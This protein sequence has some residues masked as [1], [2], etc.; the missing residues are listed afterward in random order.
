[1]HYTE[2]TDQRAFNVKQNVRLDL[3][4]LHVIP[5]AGAGYERSR[6]PLNF[7]LDGRLE[8]T[9]THAG[10]GVEFK[11]GERTSFDLEGV[12]RRIS[13][14]DET[15]GGVDL[16]ERL[17]RETEEARLSFRYAL[18]PLTTFVA[19]T[20][21]QRDRFEFDPIRDSDSLRIV[22]GLEFE[23]FALISG[24]VMIGVQQFETRDDEVPDFT[25]LVAEVD[26]AYTVR[27]VV[28]FTVRSTRDVQYS[29]EPLEPFFVNSGVE[30]EVVR[31]IGLSWD[32]VARAGRTTLAYQA[33]ED[34]RLLGHAERTDLVT[35][36]GAG[37][38]R[39]LGEEIR[40]GIDII[41]TD[42]R[43]DRP[44]RGYSG[45]RTGGSLTYGF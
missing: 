43:S 17:N 34:G 38:G 42:R 45:W 24:S 11:P 6:R 15:F 23:P 9:R 18:T 32:V 2:A 40:V 29:I 33:T 39:H 4:L 20:G 12:K 14:G 26:V 27:D 8:E 28:R 3:D 1:V 16:S 5:H 35:R 31:V 41:H 30:F 22:P 10:I 25:G 19:T 37:I 36:Y 44:G 13:Y 7:E 21:L